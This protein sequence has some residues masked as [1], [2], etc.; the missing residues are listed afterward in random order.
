MPSHLPSIPR[1]D[2]I[3]IRALSATSLPALLAAFLLAAALAA[4]LVSPPAA[5]AKKPKDADELFNPMLGPD[6]AFW[7]AG[8]IVRIATEE[9]VEEYLFLVDDAEAKAFVE[10]FWAERN[11][12]TPVF[13][14]TP[15]EIFHQRAE[16]ADKRF[17]EGTLPGRRTDRGAIFVVYGE[18]EKIEFETQDVLGQPPIEVWHYPEDAEEGLD[19]E[20]PK[21]RYR[22]IEV[23]GETVLFQG[24]KIREDPR[25]RIKRRSRWVG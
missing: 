13:E 24:Q 14:D 12:G 9:E 3:R 2:P 22:F 10:E 4:A 21:E 5:E 19:G 25:D 18:P 7:L 23:D 20:E 15:E 8:P 11:E 17:T 1:T 16:E 6:Y